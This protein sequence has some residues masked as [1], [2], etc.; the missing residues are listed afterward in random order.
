SL[1]AC[2]AKTCLYA[3]A[4]WPRHRAHSPDPRPPRR[5]PPA[6]GRRSR[7]RRAHRRRAVAPDAARMAPAPAAPAHG[8]RDELRGAAPGGLRRLLVVARMNGRRGLV[9]VISGPSGVGKD[10]LIDR[11]LVTDPNLR[12]SVSFTTRHPRANDKDGVD[13]SFVPRD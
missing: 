3:R 12:R 4:L 8:P 10:A 1:R 11:L 2:R 5:V 7:L 9:F 6:G 13:Y